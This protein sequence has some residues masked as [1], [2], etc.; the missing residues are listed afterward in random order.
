MAE[1]SDINLTHPELGDATP[2]EAIL[3]GDGIVGDASHKDNAT[4]SLG[5]IVATVSRLAA[6]VSRQPKFGGSGEFAGPSLL[7]LNPE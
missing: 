6:N 7:L 1:P 2:A 5:T 3:V 4:D